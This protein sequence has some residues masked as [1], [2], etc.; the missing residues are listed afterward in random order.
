MKRSIITGIILA[1]AVVVVSGAGAAVLFNKFNVQDR[2][3]DNTEKQSDNEAE[4]VPAAVL[5]GW[6]KESDVWYFYADN[7][8]QTEWIKDNNSWYYLGSD[9]KMRTGWIKDKEQWYYLYEDGTMAVNT[10]IDSCY[11]NEQGLIEETPKPVKKETKTVS[12]E[13]YSTVIN[14][15]EALNIVQRNDAAIISSFLEP[16]LEFSGM[17]AQD[18]INHI[19]NSYQNI[20]INE[21][22]YIFSLFEYGYDLEEYGEYG[23]PVYCYYVG[24]KTGRMYR[25][26][27]HSLSDIY[28]IKNNVKTKTYRYIS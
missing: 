1:M 26:S 7:V 28:E 4:E 10:T 25:S 23:D 5:N 14:E 3:M 13:N 8:K 19:N 12:A 2:F 18:S 21:P 16:K 17:A 15:N 6:N 20:N 11:L 24:K 27:G 22:V 9:G